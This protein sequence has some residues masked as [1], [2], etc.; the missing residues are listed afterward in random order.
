MLK[1]IIVFLELQINGKV[2]HL[3]LLFNGVRQL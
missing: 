3:N 2:C 1:N